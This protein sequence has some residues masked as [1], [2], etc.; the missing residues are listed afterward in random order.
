MRCESSIVDASRKTQTLTRSVS[1]L[2]GWVDT[3]PSSSRTA[4]SG[5][6]CSSRTSRATAS[7]ARPIPNSL[8]PPV[9]RTRW[10]RP[11]R[12]PT[13]VT[14]SRLISKRKK[15]PPGRGSVFVSCS[16]FSVSH[17]VASLYSL[18]V[19]VPLVSGHSVTLSYVAHEGYYSK[20]RAPSLRGKSGWP[21]EQVR[22]R[23]ISLE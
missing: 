7:S 9:W 17:L 15:V 11:T 4:S 5:P 23:G 6:S 1:A 13:S 3:S 16:I 10:S 14:S 20:S 22:L 19:W 21:R 18:L 12:T 2:A 8:P